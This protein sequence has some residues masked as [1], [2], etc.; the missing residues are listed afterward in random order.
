MDFF[1]GMEPSQIINTINQGMDSTL[2]FVARVVG[3]CSMFGAILEHCRGA[4][5]LANSLIKKFGDKNASGA[6][7]L[8]N[9]NDSGF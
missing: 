8:S 5:A 1:S 2:G 4:E 6:L 3:L 7:I 9:V